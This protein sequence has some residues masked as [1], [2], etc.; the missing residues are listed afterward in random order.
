MKVVKVQSDGS[1]DFDASVKF[2]ITIDLVVPAGK[3]LS[4]VNVINGTLN[5]TTVTAQLGK[6]ES[7]TI[8]G[9]PEGT[10]YTISEAGK[11]YFAPVA[12]QNG[13][14]LGD[15]QAVVA[16]KNT[17]TKPTPVISVTPKPT[18]GPTPVVSIT[19][20]PTDTPTP[21][22]TDTPTPVPT[23][24]PT[25]VPT[26]TPTPIPTDTPTPVPTKTP[27]PV[28]TK[29]PTPVPT[30]TPTPIPTPTDTPVP[31]PTDTPTPAPTDTPVPSPTNTPTPPTDEDVSG[32]HRTPSGTPTPSS[33]TDGAG[34]PPRVKTGDAPINGRIGFAVFLIIAGLAIVIFRKRILAKVEEDK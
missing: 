1:D 12:D 18:D 14:I 5:G 24:T 10:T 4:K 32:G 16:L 27:T 26:D 29:T 2:A 15:S 13:S 6:D 3:D 9:L 30:D 20:K 21:I 11:E 7:V 17:Y 34:R 23:D 25:P 8:N 22:P 19:P 31:V 28:P 33:D